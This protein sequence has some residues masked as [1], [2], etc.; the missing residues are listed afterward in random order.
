[1][2]DEVEPVLFDNVSTRT[3]L[4]YRMKDLGA[5]IRTGGKPHLRFTILK[6]L[7]TAAG[8]TDL[9]T[10]TPVRADPVTS[11]IYEWKQIQCPVQ[12]SGLDMIKTGTEG[13]EDLLRLMIESAETSMREAIGGSDV[14]I[15]S[16]ADETNLRAISGLQNHFTSSTTTGLVGNLNRATLTKWRHQSGTAAGAF[17]ANGLNV[18]STLF[19]QCSRYDETPDTIILTGSAWDNFLKETTRSFSVNLPLAADQDMVDAGFL[20]EAPLATCER[21]K[22]GE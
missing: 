16:S 12:V 8:Y 15:F 18:M 11:A 10:L 4:L 5:I 20:M 9:D 14:G 17:D 13:I 6:E 3:N 21:H 1:M 2:R 19:R 22:Y 7:P